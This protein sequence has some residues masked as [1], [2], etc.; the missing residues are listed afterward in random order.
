[1]NIDDLRQHCLEVTVEINE[2][3]K[4]LRDY[5]VTPG[6]SWL[7]R[8]ELSIVQTLLSDLEQSIDAIKRAES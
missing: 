4:L 3:M 2:H 5:S 8:N 1:M 7:A 6:N